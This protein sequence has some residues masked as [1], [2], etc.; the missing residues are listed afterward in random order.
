MEE[1]DLTMD[2]FNARVKSP[3]RDWR[4]QKLANPGV[5]SE[6]REHILTWA[7]ESPQIHR[8][9]ATDILLYDFAVTVFKK[10]TTESLGTVWHNS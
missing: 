6:V 1:W 9:M 8:A 4:E 7:H 5:A 10:Q 3:V 2:L